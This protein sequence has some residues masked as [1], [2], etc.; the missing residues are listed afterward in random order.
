MC[1]Y[2]SLFKST[3]PAARGGVTGPVD[4]HSAASGSDPSCAQLGDVY[5]GCAHVFPYVL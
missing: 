5:H 1:M 4:K 2:V 3:E